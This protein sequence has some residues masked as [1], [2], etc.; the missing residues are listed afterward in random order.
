VNRFTT[1]VFRNI[2]VADSP[3][4]LKNRLEAYGIPS[5]NNIV[6]IT[7]YVMVELGQPLHAQDLAKMEAQEI[8]IRKARKGET[9][10]TLLGDIVEV[11][12]EAFVLTQHDTPT[13][14]GGVVGGINTSVDTATTDI[15]LDAGN[16]NQN[17]IRKVSRAL[18]IQNETVLR[19]DKFLHPKLTEIAIQ[20]ATKLILELAGGD[21][22][23]NID[24][25][26]KE[27]PEKELKIRFD[28][29]KKISGMDIASEKVEKIL[30]KL[31]YEILYSDDEGH[32]VKVPYFRTDVEVEDDIVSD[33]LRIGNYQTIP[34]T[35]ITAPPP[36]EI[37][38]EI[39]SFEDHL[40]DMCVKMGLHEHITEPLVT[41]NEA[42][43]N[44]IMLENA[45]SSEQNALRTTLY[46][47]LA[48]IL[49]AYDKHR[50]YN[51]GVFEIAR[52]Y[53][54]AAHAKTEKYTETRVLE[55]VYRDFSDNPKKTAE[56]VKTYLA[57]LLYELGLAAAEYKKTNAA[58]DI[59][60]EDE[61]L[62]QLRYDS[63]TLYTEK[64][65]A[66]Q[67][68]NTRVVSQ[69]RNLKTEDISLAV[70]KE[71]QLGPIITTIR[72]AESNIANVSVADTY[73]GEIL[74]KDKKGILLRVVHTLEDFQKTRKELSA[75]LSK[76]FGVEMR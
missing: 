70:P 61:V 17:T 41:Y 73:A 9:V 36:K 15:V 60:F 14:I 76:E 29:L 28:R 12:P 63:F 4:W 43:P 2:K 3:D 6:D 35:P 53:T 37:T 5:I 49:T 65:M 25:Y 21:Y 11:I 30:N 72:R 57:T 42:N 47:T 7:N 20:R 10:T 19:C 46:E 62:G 75:I 52:I 32:F 67:Q 66:C 68:A 1:V 64:L 26:P 74:S 8:I 39:Y 55:V 18:K 23:E 54:K 27:H 45:L 22:Y 34:I 56:K 48:P 33:I 24:W 58:V 40:K 31:E 13:V 38:P 44:Q 16:Y 71:Q 59:I 51:I 69:Y 50:V